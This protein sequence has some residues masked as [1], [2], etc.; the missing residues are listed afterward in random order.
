MALNRQRRLFVTEF[1]VD[2]NATQ[3]AIRAGYSPKTAASQ[4]HRLLRNAEILEA[5]KVGFEQII[6][7]VELTEDMVLRRLMAIA[8]ADL[9]DVVQWDESGEIRM[10]PSAALSDDAAAA[11]REVRS[12]TSTVTFKD[13]GERSTVYKAVKFHD[14]IKALE[15]LGKYLKMFVEQLEH[16]GNVGI[17]IGRLHELAEA[18]RKRRR[19]HGE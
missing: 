11:L 2:R 6:Q 4:G 8:F 13:G 10:I 14:Q 17:T 1:L 18:A 3:A 15:L 19:E 12:T 5:I 16:S 9:R 7:R